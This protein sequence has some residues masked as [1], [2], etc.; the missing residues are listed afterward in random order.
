MS[1]AIQPPH[2]L[3]SCHSVRSARNQPWADV[4]LIFFAISCVSKWGL[5]CWTQKNWY[6][7]MLICLHKYGVLEDKL[8]GSSS[9]CVCPFGKAMIAVIFVVVLQQLTT[10]PDWLLLHSSM[11][12][13]VNLSIW[14]GRENRSFRGD[15][16]LRRAISCALKR[17]PPKKIVLYGWERH[18]ST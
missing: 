3:P 4:M 15:F 10:Y 9:I 11:F 14:E 17:A 18:K 6:G 12:S 7:L 16:P 5:P 8:P 13:F 1:I 2:L